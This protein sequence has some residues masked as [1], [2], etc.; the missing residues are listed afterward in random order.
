M[1]K[2]KGRT[3]VPSQAWYVRKSY[4]R[5]RKFMKIHYYF[6]WF[7][8]PMPEQLVKL[9]LNDISERK[10]LVFIGSEPSNYEFNAE[11][12]G[13]AK[14]KWLDPAGVNFEEYH[15]IDYCIA[16]EEAHKL[17]K[18][19]SAIFLLGGH[20]ALQ[21]AFLNE[22]DLPKA[23][24]ESKASVIMG[25]SAGAMNM[26]AKWISSKHLPNSRRYTTGESKVYD[27]LGIDNFALEAHIEF[28]NVGL[29]QN[30]LFSLSQ[31]IDVYATDYDS[32]IR[33]NDGKVEFFGNVYLISDSNIVKMQATN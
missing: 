17:L 22:Y 13:I 28:D 19:A 18:D 27:G 31:N 33:V 10:S 23:I 2:P 26:S 8:N 11:Q 12:V 7:N 29:I 3:Y 14:D 15:L 5:S 9:L 25:V 21:K 16:K 30:E 4:I 32:V 6:D 20:A 1:L 24:N